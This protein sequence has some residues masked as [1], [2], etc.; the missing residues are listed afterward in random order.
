MRRMPKHILL[1]SDMANPMYNC[2]MRS[3]EE[4]FMVV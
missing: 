3:H 2:G 1:N 4:N